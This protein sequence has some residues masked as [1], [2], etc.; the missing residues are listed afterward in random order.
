MWWLF[1]ILY[2]IGI[3]VL[4]FLAGKLQLINLHSDYDITNFIIALLL[5]PVLIC[6][7]LPIFLGI[8]LYKYGAYCT[9]NTSKTFWEYFK[10]GL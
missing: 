3:F 1:L 5:W 7:A 6:F 4:C 10:E 8:L 2:I 9:K